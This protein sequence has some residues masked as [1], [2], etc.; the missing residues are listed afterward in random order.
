MMFILGMMAG[1]FIATIFMCIFFV[2]KD[3]NDGE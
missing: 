1:G 3:R 2:S